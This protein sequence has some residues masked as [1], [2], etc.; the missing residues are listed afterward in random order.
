MAIV[1]G[2]FKLNLLETR[3]KSPLNQ[4]FKSTIRLV[5]IE[6]NVKHKKN[7]LIHGVGRRKPPA[8]YK[9]DRDYCHFQKPAHFFIRPLPKIFRRTLSP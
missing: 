6:N 3:N 4:F 1:C 2:G 5:K 8:G 7:G 9:S